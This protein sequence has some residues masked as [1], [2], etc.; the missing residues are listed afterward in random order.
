MSVT[1]Y[2][3][4]PDYQN[5]FNAV[6]RPFAIKYPELEKYVQFEYVSM[7]RDGAENAV[8]ATSMHGQYEAFMDLIYLC[9]EHYAPEAFVEGQA[10]YNTNGSNCMAAHVTNADVRNSIEL[11]ALEG[12]GHGLL[13]K[14]EQR[15]AALQ[16]GWSPSVYFDD[17][18]VC[19]YNDAA[20]AER[21]CATSF[22]ADGDGFAKYLC[23]STKVGGA[24]E[25]A[26]I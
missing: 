11:C 21:D 23:A 1:A 7:A 22:F 9:Y 25:C 13:R 4:C 26:N 24:S 17:V 5:F 18:L 8:G 14:S 15:V 19:L 16:A 2:S 12:F 10:C 3:Q 20:D 6:Y